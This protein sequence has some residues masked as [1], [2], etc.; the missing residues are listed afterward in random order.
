MRFV[1]HA[2]RWDPTD[3]AIIPFIIDKTKDAAADA[4]MSTI[5][6]VLQSIGQ[7]LLHNG[8]PLAAEGLLLWGLIC[9]LIACSGAGKWLER[10]TRAVLFSVLLGV[11]HIVT[12][13]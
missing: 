1:Y 4:V 5:S 2:G 6:H 10:G 7:W 13:V 3:G 12:S 11:S 8:I 9:Y